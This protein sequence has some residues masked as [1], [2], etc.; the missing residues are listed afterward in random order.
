MTNILYRIDKQLSD[1]TK[2]EKIIADYILK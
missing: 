2:T 1:F